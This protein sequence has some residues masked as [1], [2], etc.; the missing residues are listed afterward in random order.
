MREYI[1]QLRTELGLRLL[2]KVYADEHSQPSKVSECARNCTNRINQQ[3]GGLVESVR[4][5][6]SP[7]HEMPNRVR[8]RQLIS[9]LL[10]SGGSVFQNASFSTKVSRLRVPINRK[11]DRLFYSTS[12]YPHPHGPQAVYSQL[13]QRHFQ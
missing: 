12:N 11:F 8:V 1:S 4:A 6:I 5:C 2:E 10:F 3:D 9:F 7:V 13:L